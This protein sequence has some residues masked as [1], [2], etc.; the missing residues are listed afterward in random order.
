MCIGTVAGR[1]IIG[2]LAIGGLVAPIGE[3]I[4]LARINIA[5]Y[6]LF[7]TARKS[8]DDGRGPD[9]NKRNAPA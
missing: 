3:A 1:T 8:C 7:F 9:Q 2:W 4:L 5:A 6:V